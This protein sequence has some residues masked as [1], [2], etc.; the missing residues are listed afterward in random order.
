MA[1]PPCRRRLLPAHLD[2]LAGRILA[3]LIGMSL[4][5]ILGGG[6]I[7]QDERKDRFEERNLAYLIDDVTTLVWLLQDAST[8]ERARVIER[9]SRTGDQI[10]VTAAPSLGLNWPW[11][12]AVEHVIH[13]KLRSALGIEDRESLRVRVEIDERRGD[14]E[15][16]RPEP[17]PDVHP[18]HQDNRPTAGIDGRLQDREETQPSPS[19]DPRQ[20][21]ENIRTH[22]VKA[23]V[24]C[25]RLRD[26]DWVNFR[27][28]RI[29][30]PPPWA[31]KTLQLLGLLLVAA[32]G[33]GLFIARK[34]ARSM[35][36]LAE[37]A[38]RFGH[39]EDPPRLREHGPRE[40]RETIRA[41]NQ[42]QERLHKH[43]QD[44]SRLLAAVSH[45][46]RTPITILRLRAEYIDDTDMREKTL[47]TLEEMEAILSATLGFARDE[48]ADEA[49]RSTDLA[50]LVQTL[51]DDHVDL[52]GEVAYEGP[53]RLVARCRPV[54]LKRAIS[55]LIDNAVKY[56]GRV[57]VTVREE[58]G[59]RVIQIDDAGPGIPD[60]Q[61]EKVFEPFFRLEAS[62]SRETG[63]TGLGLAVARTIVHAHG[64]M[65]RLTNRPEGGLR[66]SI[67]LPEQEK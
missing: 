51:V 45:D 50:A 21:R 55:N 38:H 49:A 46:L 7:L 61:I 65:L 66:V 18:S 8:D 9:F 5:L 10:D 23:I 67:R 25:A 27:T 43:I 52:G 3:L 13:H 16:K 40:V 6:L 2:T 22:D 35:A 63:G 30:Q 32:I 48:A 62:R 64:G 41:I 37:A 14:T 57:R 53:E 56:G 17:P 59:S 1:R 12:H 36:D 34:T 24:I 60:A 28:T 33:T 54:S 44:R 20:L 15:A 4:V 31:G 58:P 11:R 19:M 39:G 47:A 26:G 42:M 29:D